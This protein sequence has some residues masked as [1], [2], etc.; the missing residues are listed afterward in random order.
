MKAYITMASVA[1]LSVGLVAGVPAAADPF[2]FFS[3]GSPDGKLG[4]L[5][6]PASPEGIE[7]ETADDFV[8]TDATVISRAIIHG[9]IPSGLD[10][11]SIQR[12]E[13]ELYH[14]FP[15]DSGPFD[16][17]V[18]TR[19]NSPAD[20]EIG[21]ATRDSAASPATLSFGATLVQKNFTVLNTVVNKINTAPNQFTGG[22]GAATGNE[23]EI[24]VTFTP[25]I[26]LPADHYF[27][28]PEVQVSG[29]N[30]LYLSAPRPIVSPPGTP[31]SP[32]LQSWIRNANLAPDWSRI[33]TDITQQGPFNAAFS[34]GGNPIPFAGTPGQPNCHGQTISAIA[35]EFGRLGTASGGINRAALILGFFS[36]RRA[37]GRGFGVLSRGTDVISRRLVIFE[38]GSPPLA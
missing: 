19:V 27:F 9:L 5:S 37:T 23:V 36:R 15:K 14:V 35:V 10:V 2:F 18:L 26:F 34:L 25:P 32:D 16:G 24:D 22:E 11:S 6:R 13:V 7:T 29:G 31:F 33:G 12:V 3:T 4:S 17:R 20:V 38:P 8:L 28:R 21:A 30:F 1:A